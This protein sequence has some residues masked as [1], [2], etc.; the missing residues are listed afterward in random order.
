MMVRAGRRAG[1]GGPTLPMV[2]PLEHHSASV[3]GE[4][5]L[6]WGPRGT[7]VH[8]PAGLGPLGLLRGTNLHT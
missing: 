6:C 2:M 1:A 3:P 7:S 5:A 8:S 4:A